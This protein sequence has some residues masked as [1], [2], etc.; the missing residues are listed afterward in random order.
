[1]DAAEAY[2][3]AVASL[4]R[5]LTLADLRSHGFL[6]FREYLVAY[7]QS[8]AFT[9]LTADTKALRDQLSGIRYCLRILSDRIKVSK[10]DSEADYGADVAAT[11]ERFRQREVKDYRAKFLSLADMDHVEAG[12]PTSSRRST[13]TAA[14]IAIILTG[15]LPC[16]TGRCS[17][18]SPASTSWRD[19]GGPG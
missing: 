3:D 16:S 12:V 11:F 18:T 4:A 8:S 19:S 1:L 10:Y 14:V 15:R 5:D 17:F 7:T 2:C 9:R 13:I 6:A